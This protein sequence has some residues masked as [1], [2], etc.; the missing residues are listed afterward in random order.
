MGTREK[1]LSGLNLDGHD[2]RWAAAHFSQKVAGSP[3]NVLA[4]TFIRSWLG[5][6][7]AALSASPYTKEGSGLMIFLQRLCAA[8]SP[9]PGSG[10]RLLC[11]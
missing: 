5:G 8:T 10:Q 1:S 3:L 4:M 11:M 6:H 9:V 7:W 2:M